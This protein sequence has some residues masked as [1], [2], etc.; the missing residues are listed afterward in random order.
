MENNIRKIIKENGLL[1]SYVIEKSGLAKS[2]LYDIMNGNSI[3]SLENAR[4][5][6]KVLNK[7]VDEVFPNDILK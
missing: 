4:K 1:I 6:S 5:I 2:S 3:P 7:S